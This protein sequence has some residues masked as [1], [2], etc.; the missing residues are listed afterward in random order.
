MTVSAI[1]AR[2]PGFERA[3][4]LCES[5]SL[6]GNE[7]QH[8]VRDDDRDAL[9]VGQQ[10]CRV[11]VTQA[12]VGKPAAGGSGRV[13]RRDVERGPLLVFFATTALALACAAPSATSSVCAGRLY[14]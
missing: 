2:P 9:T 3:D 10:G 6:V 4:D 14:A 8:T 12:D 1:C 5:A 11:A 7:V 13:D